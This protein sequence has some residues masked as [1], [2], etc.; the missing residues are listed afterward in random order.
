MAAELVA[1]LRLAL[2]GDAVG[3]RELAGRSHTLPDALADRINEWAVG[4]E[5]GDVI[6]EDTG[7]G[8]AVIEDYVTDVENILLSA[9]TRQNSD[10]KGYAYE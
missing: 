4:S 10:R 3:Q 9:D 7:E 2:A 8:Y 6:L 5:I 1:F